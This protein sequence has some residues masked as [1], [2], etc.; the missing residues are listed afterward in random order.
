MLDLPRSDRDTLDTGL[1]LMRET[2]ARL[3]GTVYSDALSPP[4]GPAATYLAMFRHNTA[5]FADAMRSG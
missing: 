1:M 5:L 2:G 4:G 3:G